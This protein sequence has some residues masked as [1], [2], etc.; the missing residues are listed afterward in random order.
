M[1]DR[2]RRGRLLGKTALITGGGSGIGRATAGLFAAEGAS[3]VVIVDCDADGA[4]AVAGEVEA[5]GADAVVVNADVTDVDAP[6][7]TV[8]DVVGRFDRLDVIMTAAGI[9]VGRSLPNTD[10]DD[11]DRVFAVNVK[12]TYLWLRAA[13]PAMVEGGGGSVITVASQLAVS[14]GRSNAAYIASKGAIVSLT[15]TTAVDFAT[16]GVRVNSILPGATETPLLDR[17]FGRLAEPEQARQRSVDRHPMGRFG[18][19]EEIAQAALY[20]ASDESTFTTGAEI[21][22]D[23]GWIAG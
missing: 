18:R 15:R 8:A 1:V 4:A 12:G 20:L 17:S 14:G 23:G 13:I 3:A 9:S 19:P 21:R 10:P 6:Q 2:T 16:H 5:A 11:W 22:V 7:R